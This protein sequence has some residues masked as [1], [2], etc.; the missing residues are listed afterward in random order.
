VA[1]ASDSVHA[2]VEGFVEDD[3]DFGVGAEGR[4]SKKENR[5]K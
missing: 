2:F 4:E 1:G 3:A 5:E